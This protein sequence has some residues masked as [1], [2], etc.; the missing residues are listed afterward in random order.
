MFNCELQMITYWEQVII[1]QSKINANS[2]MPVAGGLVKVARIH[3]KCGYGILSN[4]TRDI[5]N[6]N[7]T[8]FVPITLKF[9][10][11]YSDRLNFPA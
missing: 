9:V 5:R 2:R 1:K 3:V 4:E 8:Q 6:D 11:D 10:R 7:P